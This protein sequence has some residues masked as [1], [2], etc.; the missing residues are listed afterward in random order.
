MRTPA[1][2]RR[3]A[4]RAGETGSPV[5][6][7]PCS[8]QQQRNSHTGTNTT[9]HSHCI[10][11]SVRYQANKRTSRQRLAYWRGAAC[12]TP[13]DSDAIGTLSGAICIKHQ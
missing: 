7:P 5:A 11:L 4:P 3:A 6:S 9:G 12:M 8:L 13:H 1:A 10:T 2:C